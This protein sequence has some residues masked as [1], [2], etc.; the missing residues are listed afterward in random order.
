M[1]CCHLCNKNAQKISNIECEKDNLKTSKGLEIKDSKGQNLLTFKISLDNDLNDEEYENNKKIIIIDDSYQNNYLYIQQNNPMITMIFGQKPQELCREFLAVFETIYQLSFELTTTY[2]TLNFENVKNIIEDFKQKQKFI[3][4]I[5]DKLFSFVINNRKDIEE[6]DDIDIYKIFDVLFL[7]NPDFQIEVIK[8]A[9][10]FCMKKDNFNSN[11]ISYSF[12]KLFQDIG[13]CIRILYCS[14]NAHILNDNYCYDYSFDIRIL[15][16]CNL[17]ANVAYKFEYPSHLMKLA[18]ESSKIKDTIILGD[19]Q[20]RSHIKGLNL[21]CIRINE[22]EDNKLDSFFEKPYIEKEK[23]KVIKYFVICQDVKLENKYLQEFK[24]LSCKYGFSYLFIVYVKNKKLIDIKD[25]LKFLTSIY[26][27]FD[28]L[29]LIEIYKD[30]NERL[31]PR[32]AGYLPEN[33][34]FPEFKKASD[35]LNEIINENI[36]DLKSSSEDGW[37]LFEYNKDNYHLGMN[38]IAGCFHN[39]IS[40]IIGHFIESYKER[41]ALEFFFQYYSNYFFLTLQPEFLV[42]MTAYAKM[43]LYAYTLEERDPNKNLYCVLNNDLRSSDP[44]KI[45]RHQELIKLIGALIKSKKLKSYNGNLYRATYLKDELI[46]KIKIGLTMLNSA[47][48]SATKKES[49]AKNFLKQNYKNALIITKGG[50]QN[51]IDIHLEKMS[52]YPNEEEVLFLPFCNFK[53]I[54]FD[55]VK[56][57]NLS[58]Y[59]LVLENES[60]SS[61]IEPY[62]EEIIKT[63][64]F[65]RKID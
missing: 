21:S 43:F 50:L 56:E 60:D 20:F 35:E 34:Q 18:T 31:R 24:R 13:F 1:G 5:S 54:S 17:I 14:L 59:K 38:I 36:R 29:E 48:W 55:K 42:N 57:G 46:T 52:R 40:H 30:N 11:N 23:Y 22:L 53:I 47:F 49:V 25:S 6:Y 28:D 15:Y 64:D 26:Y 9:L 62:R 33:E 61:L 8:S 4:V 44:S 19:K 41:N 3:P 27:F 2:Y 12:I 45:N 63:F 65:E 32:L 16:F 7:S 58:Y 39:Y 37:D 10:S 51:N